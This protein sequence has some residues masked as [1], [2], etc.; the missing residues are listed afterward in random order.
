MARIAILALLIFSGCAALDTW[1]RE[2]DP[3]LLR[4]GNL[5]T[6]DMREPIHEKC[7]E[8]KGVWGGTVDGRVWMHYHPREGRT[9]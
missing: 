7:R 4:Y 2:F 6:C 5:P 8:V 1:T 9:P 3:L